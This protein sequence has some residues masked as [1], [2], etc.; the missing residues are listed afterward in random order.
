MTSPITYPPGQISQL[1]INRALT[2][3]Y[4]WISY[5]GVDGS[6]WYLSGPLAPEPGAQDGM[7][8]KKHM[9]LMSPFE[10]LEQRGARQDGAT[11]QDAVYDVGSIMLGLEASGTS[12]QDIRNVLR[13]WISAW[14]PKQT[15]VL[16]VFT[17]DMGEW[18]ANVR[19]GKNISDMF[20]RDYTWS[21]SQPLTWEA[22]NYDAFWYSVDS[23][24]TFSMSYNTVL[25]NFGNES[26]SFTLNPTNWTQLI[27]PSGIGQYGIQFS[28]ANTLG[29]AYFMPSNNSGPAHVININTATSATNNQ[30]VS[31]QLAGAHFYNL[32][33]FIDPGA[34]FDIIARINGSGT[35]YV[36][37]S[38]GPLFYSLFFVNGGTTTTI[39]QLPL[40]VPPQ[41][42]ELWTLIAG[43]AASPYQYIIQRSGFT[44]MNYTDGAQTSV[45]GSSNRHW[46]FGVQSTVVGGQVVIPPPIQQFSA[47][48]NTAATQS[49]TINL[50]NFG[51]QPAWPR[52]LCYGPG[53]F[54][55]PNGPGGGSVTFG[56]LVDG[57]I[58]LVTTDPQYR[59]VVDITP[60][61]QFQV[62]N[63][64]QSVIAGLI[65]FATNNNVPPLLQQ[66]ESL[67]G[68]LPPQGNLYSLLNGRFT[69]PIPGASYG[70][71]PQTYALPVAITGGGPTGQVVAA[72]T[73]RRRWPL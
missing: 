59:S 4:S 28:S 25:E 12:P 30:V 45:V 26:N 64:F 8:L 29:A 17:P 7:A 19:M 40:I 46:G 42:G 20:E 52:F 16:S 60:G 22:K 53:T 66:F 27:T 62:L 35:Q 44:I 57:Q 63:Q 3:Q 48:D 14:D 13:Q 5:I 58:V 56:P 18:W 10:M 24:S 61:Q 65:S 69:N 68:I 47:A 73:P 67:F 49:G 43:T 72:I 38:V 55:L 1:G 21:G 39:F 11:W 6:I 51:D 71:L 70:T 36:L 9:G 31:V 41:P 23:T 50:T 34:N 2:N 32:F 54:T 37:L 15:G 33:D